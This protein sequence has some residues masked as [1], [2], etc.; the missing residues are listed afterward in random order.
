MYVGRTSSNELE[1]GAKGFAPFQFGYRHLVEVAS[2]C[3]FGA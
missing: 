1:N 3:R 2:V